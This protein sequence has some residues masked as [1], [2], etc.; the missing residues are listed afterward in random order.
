MNFVIELSKQLV[1]NKNLNKKINDN[2]VLWLYILK[3]Q[4]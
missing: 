3:G 1:D 2:H 4:F